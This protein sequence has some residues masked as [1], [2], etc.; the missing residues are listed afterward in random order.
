MPDEKPE[1]DDQKAEE[2]RRKNCHYF[3]GVAAKK[4]N[5]AK[6]HDAQTCKS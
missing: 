5:D 1:D 4:Q 6:K 2:N 3:V